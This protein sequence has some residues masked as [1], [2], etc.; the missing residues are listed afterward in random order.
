VEFLPIAAELQDANAVGMF[1]LCAGFADIQCKSIYTCKMFDMEMMERMSEQMGDRGEEMGDMDANME[2]ASGFTS[3][4]D[5]GGASRAGQRSNS[6]G[7]GDGGA[8]G[9]SEM[10]SNIS[11][12]AGKGLCVSADMAAGWDSYGSQYEI[13][14]VS[15]VRDGGYKF[16]KKLRWGMDVYWDLMDKQGNVLEANGDYLNA[17]SI[18]IALVASLGPGWIGFGMGT[19]GAMLGANALIGWYDA[20]NTTNTRIKE[21][22][23]EEKLPWMIK[24]IKS[25]SESMEIS[26]MEIIN[27]GHENALIM[28]R[29]LK[30]TNGMAPILP[31]DTTIIYAVGNTPRPVDDYFGY[32][33]FR[34]VSTVAFIPETFA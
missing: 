9:F 33:R 16:Y 7:A 13:A 18:K 27:Q 19:S 28:E 22:Y 21:Y 5:W 11:A 4:S 34:E 1:S 17:H 26:N 20:A 6:S 10:F 23:L 29:P 31:G 12:L 32:H 2:N 14:G 24:P 30:P 25:N 8:K 3:A 15:A